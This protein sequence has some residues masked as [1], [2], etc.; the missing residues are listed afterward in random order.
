MHR[1]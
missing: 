1:L